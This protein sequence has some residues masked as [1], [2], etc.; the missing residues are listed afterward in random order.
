[1]FLDSAESSGMMTNMET[2]R[3]T[4]SGSPC[5]APG[6]RQIDFGTMGP[7]PIRTAPV[8]TQDT[9]GMATVIGGAS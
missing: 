6:G 9:S 3:V 5:S 7:P 1:M 2:T 4:K 8:R